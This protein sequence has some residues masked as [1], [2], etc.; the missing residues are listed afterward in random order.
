MSSRPII[1]MS[2]CCVTWQWNTVYRVTA[3]IQTRHREAIRIST[4]ISTVVHR[5]HSNHD[6]GDDLRLCV[7]PFSDPEEIGFNSLTKE[8]LH[9]TIATIMVSR[10][11]NPASEKRGLNSLP[12]NDAREG[13]TRAAPHLA[14]TKD[15]GMGLH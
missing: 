12:G 8:V 10:E 15:R 9:L 4:H 3:A 11:S 5:L 1:P 2:S 14:Q 6:A 13:E 7:S